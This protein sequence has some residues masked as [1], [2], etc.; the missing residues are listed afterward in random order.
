MPA[1]LDKSYNKMSVCVRIKMRFPEHFVQQVAQATDIVDLVGQYV[2]LKRKGREMV[3]LCPFHDDKRPSLNVSPAKQIFKCFACGAGGGVFQ[4][5]Q[6]YEKVSFPEAVRT[7]ASRAN[8][9]LP[10]EAL[11]PSQEGGLSKADLVKVTT[12]AARFFRKQ[13]NSPAGKSALEYVQNRGLSDE[14]ITRFGIGY[15]QDSWDALLRAALRDGIGEGQLVAAG[16]AARREERPGCYD[17]FRNRLIF[18][19]IN[20]AGEVIA[21]GGRA[22]AEGE[23]KYINSPDTALFDKS[24]Q[25]YALNWARESIVASGQAVVV[26]G[27]FDALMPHQCGVTNVVATLGTALTDRHVRLLSRYAEQIVL[28]FDADE[29]GS[30]A[31]E[32]ALELFLAQQVHVRVVAIPDGKDPCDYCL[33]HGGQAFAELVRQAPGALEY[34]WNKRRQA[35][36]TS[37]DNLAGRRRAVEDFLRLVATSSAYGSIDEVRRG[38][39]AQHIG[40]LLN[41]SPTE[42]QQ[43]LR[44]LARRVGAPSAQPAPTG[45]AGLTQ[46][47]GDA[48]RQMLEVLLNCPD[49]FD[50]AA[51]QIEPGDFDDS[52]LQTIAKS[53][54]RL[55]KAGRLSLEELLASEDMS[56]AAPLITELANTGEKRGN[57][58][59]TLAGA[60][61]HMIYR[62]SR[63]KLQE[64]RSSE[65][66]DDSLR[67]L[68][69]HFRQADIRRHPKIT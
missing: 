60:V 28:V 48:Q 57:Y 29:A 18:P 10:K 33:A 59:Q 12:Y 24:S 32:R 42:L 61:E 35:V 47:L 62:R 20:P 54:W 43:Q 39:L 44:R 63:Q 37:G 4:F 49:L 25:L 31:A 69:Q 5:L 55:G 11:A 34:I 52:V 68:D 58:E 41:V 50:Q 26:E 66:N 30:A 6:L 56:T 7:L 38:Q 15:A 1:G 36:E 13:L 27:Y 46:P 64:L 53:I 8:I 14:S 9:P 3:G 19:I 45:T 67:K 17:R 21:F 2:A 16:L 51:E 65:L 40:H 23:A 22:M